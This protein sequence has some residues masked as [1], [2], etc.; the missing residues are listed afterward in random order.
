LRCESIDFFL[1]LLGHDSSCEAA[2][3]SKDS[4]HKAI[5]KIQKE[6]VDVKKIAKE[7]KKEIEPKV[8]SF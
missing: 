1:D 5:N 2:K 8:S 7:T 3:L 4:Q 6:W